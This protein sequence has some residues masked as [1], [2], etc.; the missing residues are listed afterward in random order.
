MPQHYTVDFCLL[1]PHYN[2]EAGL[3]RSLQ[4]VQYNGPFLVSV[5]DDGSTLPPNE[6]VLKKAL[7]AGFPL[8][9][10]YLGEN[11]GITIALNAGLQWIQQHCITDFIARLDC[12]DVCL[13]GRFET[14]LKYL[15]LHPATV[16]LGTWCRFKNSSTGKSF[17]HTSVTAPA[18]VYR[19]MHYRNIIIHPTVMFKKDAA[20]QVQGYPA[21]Y[22]YAED[23][24]FFWHL[25]SVGDAAV[26]P[27]EFV[28]CNINNNGISARHRKQ[29][30]KSVRQIISRLAKKKWW[31]VQGFTLSWLRQIIPQS[32]IF[33]V[34]ADKTGKK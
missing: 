1:V 22:P 5:V 9:I 2:N 8:Q 31:A 3:L 30:L 21:G 18:D 17:L 34:K 20:Q 15:R 11:R 26:L 28:C 16:L 7:P 29:Q 6:T 14:Q 25:I 23:Y 32:L 19:H 4:S 33:W 27:Q 12:D 13:P 24:A 10:I